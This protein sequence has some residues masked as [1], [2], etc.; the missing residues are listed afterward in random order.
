VVSPTFG[1]EKMHVPVM[2]VVLADGSKLP[3]YMILNCKTMPR[4]QLPRRFNVRCHPKGWMA[5]E[6]VKDCLAVVCNR[7]PGVLL[8]KWGMLLL[9]A[10]KEHQK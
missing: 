5:N 9:D 6:P 4:E 3:S 8:R 2:L 10:F 7:R 1:Y